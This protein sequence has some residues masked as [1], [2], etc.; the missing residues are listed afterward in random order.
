MSLPEVS[1]ADS[2]WVSLRPALTRPGAAEGAPSPGLRPHARLPFQHCVAVVH[3]PGRRLFSQNLVH[4]Y[5]DGALVK[6]APLRC[7]SLSEVCQAGFG[8]ALGSWGT[9]TGVGSGSP[10]RPPPARLGLEPPGTMHMQ[11]TGSL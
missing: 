9:S 10:K 4:V 7:P 2:A 5:K 11:Q 1:F 6:T 3:V 8:D